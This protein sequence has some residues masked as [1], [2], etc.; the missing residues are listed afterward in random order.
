MF[1]N[2]TAFKASFGGAIATPAT[3]LD[4]ID[5]LVSFAIPFLQLFVICN[6]YSCKFQCF[7][8][9]I[10]SYTVIDVIFHSFLRF[11][12]SFFSFS[13]LAAREGVLHLRQEVHL[14]LF[15]MW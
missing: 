2:S 5:L 7:L 12:A 13:F 14:H 1:G 4:P 10:V 3:S 11:L 15:P 8:A 6:V 9:L